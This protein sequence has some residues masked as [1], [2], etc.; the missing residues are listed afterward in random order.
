MLHVIMLHV[1]MLNVI[2]LHVVMLHVVMLHVVM[3][4]VVGPLLSLMIDKT[5][6]KKRLFSLTMSQSRSK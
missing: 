3:L 5:K 1:V 4:S 2:M 6:G